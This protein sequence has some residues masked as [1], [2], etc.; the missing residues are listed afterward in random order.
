VDVVQMIST[1][2]LLMEEI[3]MKKV[4]LIQYASKF[5]LTDNRVVKCSQEL[6][7]L[8]NHYQTFECHAPRTSRK[9]ENKLSERG[10][11]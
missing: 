7:M 9:H 5:Q 1:E 8:L 2:E 6:D 3:N 11:E 10:S 4:E